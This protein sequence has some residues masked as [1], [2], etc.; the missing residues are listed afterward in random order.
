[1]EAR[2][3]SNSS[4][5]QLS[6]SHLSVSSVEFESNDLF[7]SS[8]IRGRTFESTLLNVLLTM[9]NSSGSRTPG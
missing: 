8:L 3:L 7:R 5:S 1:M 4:A 6:V 2:T 9:A